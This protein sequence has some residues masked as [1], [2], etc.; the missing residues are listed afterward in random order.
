MNTALVDDWKLEKTLNE[1]SKLELHIENDE[2]T[3][4]EEAR[5]LFNMPFEDKPQRDG[6]K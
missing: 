2:S 4:Y 1:L 6:I 3:A 5:S